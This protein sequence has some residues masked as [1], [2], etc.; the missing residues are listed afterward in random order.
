MA[1]PDYGREEKGM[2]KKTF[3]G[4]IFSIF[5]YT[6]LTLAAV[7]TLFPLINVLAVSFSST[8]AILSGEVSLFPVDFNV[9]AYK[10]LIQDGQ[11]F[12]A[13][14]NNV[15]ITVIGTALNMIATIAAAYPLSKKRLKGQQVI[16]GLIVFTMLFG[17]GLIP[18]FILVK[19]L[20]LINTYGALWLPSLVSVYNLII[21]RTFFASIPASLEE[22]A[23]IDGANDIY[24]LLRIVIPLSLPIIFTLVL[25]YA[26]SW[27]NSYFNVLIYITSPAKQS[28]M[29]KLM[30]M[31]NNVSDSLTNSGEGA[32]QQA[33]I[34]PEA[35]KAAAIIISTTPILCVYPFL[36]K[37]FVKG[38]MIGAIKG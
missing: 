8:R 6:F 25:F 21:L 31:L 13:L 32:A 4:S 22:A 38:V 36:Q 29:V 34:T 30:Q 16:M 26:V 24:I 14:K 17:G 15:V 11:L 10:N 33:A 2:Y 23:T 37:H 19:S 35:V 9:Q 7:I 5:N 18:S 3:G 12:N 20:G 1:N 28:L 27:W